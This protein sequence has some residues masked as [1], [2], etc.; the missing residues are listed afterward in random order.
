MEINGYT[1]KLAPCNLCKDCKYC[2]NPHA[3]NFVTECLKDKSWVYIKRVQCPEFE[4][5]VMI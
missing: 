3:E 2:K 5:R 1:A 4:K